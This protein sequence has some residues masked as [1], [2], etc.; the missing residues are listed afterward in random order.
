LLPLLGRKF[1]KGYLTIPAGFGVSAL[2]ELLQLAIGRGVC[3]VDDLFCNTLGAAMGYFA[4]MTVLSLY[5]EKGKR[6]KPVLIFGCLLLSPVI[7]IGSIFVAY[8]A[9]ELGNLPMA[10][11]Y[12]QNTRHIKWTLNCNLPQETGTVAVYRTAV[13]DRAACDALAQELATLTGQ[14]VLMVS[15]Y[16]EFAYYNLSR[17]LLSIYFHDGSYAFSSGF[18]MKEDDWAETDRETLEKALE[19]FHIQIPEAAEFCY[20]G[21]GWHS[22][23]CQRY[24]SG[25]GMVD[26][27]LRCRYASDGTVPVIENHLISYIHYNNMPVVSPEEAYTRLR[28]GKFQDYGAFEY[29]ASG[30]IVVTGCTLAY[31][32]DTKGFYQ[33]VYYF[34]VA[35][36]NGSYSDRIM[37]PALE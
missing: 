1:R 7:A 11:A 37:I 3:D 16:Q 27:E 25:Q 26:G 2:I 22:F 24:I 34:D 14:E 8:E 30:E 32:V 4:V 5:N 23:S 28:V 29:Y 31:C 33:P 35:A 6:R 21:D 9:R 10:P 13:L 17:G 12:T 15:Y 18:S 19:I 20:E 36:A